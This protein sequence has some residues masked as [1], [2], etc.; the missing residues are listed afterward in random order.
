MA[1]PVAGPYVSLGAG[2]NL[3]QDESARYAPAADPANRANG[4][5]TTFRFGDGFNGEASVGFGFGNGLRTELEG[6]YYYNNVNHGRNANPSVTSGHDEKYG[7]LVNVLYD[8][9]LAQFGLALPVTPYVGVGGGYLWEHLSP[10]TSTYDDGSI[11]RTGGTSGSFAYQGIVGV[12]YNIVQVPGL[13]LTGEYRLLGTLPRETGS[14]FESTTY[15]TT[16]VHKGNA[17]FS[18]DFNHSFMVGVRYAFDTAPPPPPPAPVAPPPAPVPARTYLVFFDWDHS[19]LTSRAREII[20]EA[21]QAS[22]RVQTTRIE[23]NGY[24]DTSIAIPGAR[25]QRYNQNLSVRRAQNVKAELIRD[26]VPSTA[27]ETQGFGDTHPLVPT[28]PNTREPQNRRVEII[29]H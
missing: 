24:A 14:A 29:L 21:A 1:Q 12:A 19:D 10:F 9:D 16:G 4:T 2:Y 11:N 18:D 6:A 23:V 3:Q 8:L 27:I 13:A 5:K 22:T 25:G 28:G 15:E 7:A 26:G 17:D 20:A